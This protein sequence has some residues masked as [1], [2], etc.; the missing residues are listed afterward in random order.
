MF[1]IHYSHA[2]TRASSEPCSVPI[3]GMFRK[4]SE[5]RQHALI[6][7]TAHPH[8]ETWCVGF[9][10]EAADGEIVSAWEKHRDDALD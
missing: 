9:E 8:F 1:T 10:I 3:G 5:A 7:A 4:V 2:P 6:V